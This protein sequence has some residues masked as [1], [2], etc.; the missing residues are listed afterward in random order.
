MDFVSCRSDV[1]SYKTKH[2]YFPFFLFWLSQIDNNFAECQLRPVSQSCSRQ[3]SVADS[4]NLPKAFLVTES[5]FCL[6]PSLQE[7]F[8]KIKGYLEEELD[9]RKQALDQAY[10]V[11]TKE[12][13]QYILASTVTGHGLQL[14]HEKRFLLSSQYLFFF[15][16]YYLLSHSPNKLPC[17]VHNFKMTPRFCKSEKGRSPEV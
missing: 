15:F 4:I 6:N 3:M 10:M 2:S 12:M 7:Q 13:L 16:N 9:Y 11:C 5:R 8:C 17:N 1:S 14:D